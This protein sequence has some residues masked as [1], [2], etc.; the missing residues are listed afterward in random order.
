MKIVYCIGTFRIFVQIS[1][2]S[3]MWEQNS[4][5]LPHCIFQEDDVKNNQNFLTEFCCRGT[6]V[7]YLHDKVSHVLDKISE[8]I[9]IRI[10]R[11]LGA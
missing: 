10:L 2:P 7:N 9:P 4:F 8:N 5:S 6:L 1:N 3:S 11:S